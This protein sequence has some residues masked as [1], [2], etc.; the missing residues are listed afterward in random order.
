MSPP[1]GDEQP[2]PAVRDHSDRRCPQPGRRHGAVH[3]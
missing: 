2:L 1:A 3:H